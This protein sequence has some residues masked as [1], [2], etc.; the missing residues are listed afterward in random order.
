MPVTSASAKHEVIQECVAGKTKVRFMQRGI[1]RGWWVVNTKGQPLFFPVQ[2]LG[3]QAG[4]ARSTAV[5]PLK[6]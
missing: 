6:S 1:S 2:R 4:G 3:N 5:A